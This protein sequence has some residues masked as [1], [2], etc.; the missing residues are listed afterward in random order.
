[1]RGRTLVVDARGLWLSGIGR[2]LR[3]VLRGVFAEARFGRVTLLGRPEQLHAFVREHGAEG[4]AR[5]VPFP[6]HFYSAPAQLHWL[7]LHARGALAG[8]VAFFPH[9]DVPLTDLSA[10]TVVT[11]QDLAH[12]ALAAQFP[13]W[14][15]AMASAVLRRAVHR[16]SRVLVTSAWTRGELLARHPEAADRLAVVPLGVSPGVV[17]DEG[18]AP[19]RRARIE[20]LSPFLLCVGNRKPHKNMEA[21][22]ETLARLRPRVPGLRLVI[23]G[24]GFGEDGGVRERARRL[25]VE[26]AVSWEGRV[27]DAELACLYAHAG[28]L[29]FPSLYEGFGLPPLEAMQAGVPVVAS[30]RASI[31]EVVG[32]AA[33]VVPPHDA[34]AMAAAALRLLQDPAHRAAM[35][36]RGRERAARFR[37]EE[38][39][40]RITD[41]LWEVAEAGPGAGER[42]GRRAGAVGAGR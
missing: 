26:E 30:D 29:L 34:E 25:G 40:S 42:A 9:Y 17:S 33:A 28:C 19:E 3:E 37:W 38:T 35:V 23:A 11:V 21:A 4:V 18:V 12:F 8:D 41:L 36:R 13:A 22:V 31:P 1:M 39:A 14:K 20:A 6:Y 7:A 16:A 24:E 5:V 27:S 10:R 15:R 32:D 2:F